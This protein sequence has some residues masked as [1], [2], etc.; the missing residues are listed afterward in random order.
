MSN[1]KPISPERAEE[2]KQLLEQARSN[3][4]GIGI[5]TQTGQCVGTVP[6]ADEP[7]ED[8]TV[9]GKFDTHYA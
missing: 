6:L 4:D 8:L 7:Q 9:I 3:G 1:I 5:D 2:L